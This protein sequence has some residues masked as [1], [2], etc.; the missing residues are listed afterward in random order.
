MTATKK[1]EHVRQHSKFHDFLSGRGRWVNHAPHGQTTRGEDFLIKSEFGSVESAVVV[2]PDGSPNYD[3]PVYREAPTVNIVAY[4][5][6]ADDRIRMAVITQQRPH[7]DDPEHPGND[8][9]PVMFGQIPMGFMDRIIGKDSLERL[10]TGKD[11]AKR[12]VAEETGVGTIIKIE[13]PPYPYMYPNP[14]FCATWSD[15]F[16]VKVDLNS[17]E[18]NKFDRTELIYSAEYIPVPE[19]LRRI[20]EGKDVTGALY[21]MG[22]SLGDLMLFFACYPQYFTPE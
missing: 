15:V 17:V 20:R 4:G 10:E 1:F 22:L 16:W 13:Q 21:R 5:D 19:L 14:T 7:A 8:H 6:H 9:A 12:E 3:R 2:N 18:Q 11:C